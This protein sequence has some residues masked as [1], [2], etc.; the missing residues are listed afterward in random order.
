MNNTQELLAKEAFSFKGVGGLISKMIN[1]GMKVKPA[2]VPQNLAKMK[3]RAK[4]SINTTQGRGSGLEFKTSSTG[5]PISGGG[6]ISK[7]VGAADKNLAV[8]TPKGG[9]T[10]RTRGE[11]W[12]EFAKAN[13]ESVQTLKYAGTGVGGLAAGGLLFGGNKQEVNNYG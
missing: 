9:L 3:F 4:P 13:P 6:N 10:E 1:P 8:K 2:A 12:S 5:A 11:A 7:H